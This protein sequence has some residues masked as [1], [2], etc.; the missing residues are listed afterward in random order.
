[1]RRIFAHPEAKFSARRLK[2]ELPILRLLAPRPRPKA[3]EHIRPLA[4]SSTNDDPNMLRS[5]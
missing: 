1:M 5:G 3:P 2:V 4:T